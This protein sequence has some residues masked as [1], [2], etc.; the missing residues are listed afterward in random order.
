M[1]H[2]SPVYQEQGIPLITSKNLVGGTIDFSDVKFI[3]KEDH[4]AISKRSKVDD[5]DLLMAM[6]G[7]IG[8]ATIV[9]KDREFS[10]KN[11]ALFKFQESKKLSNFFLLYLLQSP[12]TEINLFSQQKGVTQKFIALGDLRKFTIP[13]PSLEVQKSIVN[14]IKRE[15][16]QVDSAKKLIESYEA[17]TQA[18]ITKLWSE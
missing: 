4:I 1:T 6:I 13:L 3:T 7:T 18:V 17:R 14:D 12:Y 11:V 15:K 10:I 9:K 2:D 8:N 16:E 5:G